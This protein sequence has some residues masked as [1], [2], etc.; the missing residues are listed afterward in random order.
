MEILFGKSPS[1]KLP[2]TFY[3]NDAKLP[4]F[5]D[6]SMKGRTYRYADSADIIYPFGY[7]LSYS[8][9]EKTITSKTEDEAGVHVSVKVKNLGK[10]VTDEVVQIYF[11]SAL[12]DAVPNRTLCGFKRIKDIPAGAEADIV[13]DIPFENLYLYDENGNGYVCGDYKLTAE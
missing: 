8:D 5:T 1:G 10:Y 11:S 12:P 9:T 2:V 3:R 13:I 7:G 4:D 6:Y